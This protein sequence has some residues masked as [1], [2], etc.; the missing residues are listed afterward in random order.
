MPVLRRFPLN[1]Q[2][3]SL[4]TVLPAYSPWAWTGV[5]FMAITGPF[6]ATVRLQGWHPLF[7]TLYGQTLLLKIG[8]VAVLLLTSTFHLFVLRPRL[9]KTLLSLHQMERKLRERGTEQD[10]ELSTIA[11]VK[12]LEQRIASSVRFLIRL[13]RFEAFVGTGIVLCVGL[14][15]VFAGTLPPVP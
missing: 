7:T 4:S 1:E 8:L 15:T 6:I 9:Q 14:M 11:Q 2:A 3:Q 5:G 13:L 10:E 12:H